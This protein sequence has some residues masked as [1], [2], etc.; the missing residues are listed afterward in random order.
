MSAGG[1]SYSGVVGD[2]KVTLPAV[3]SWGSNMN[4]LRDPPK[5]I[6][7]RKIDKVFD[8]QITELMA[9]ASVNDRYCENIEVYPRGINPSVSVSYGNYGNNGGKLLHFGSDKNKLGGWTDEAGRSQQWKACQVSNGNTMAKYPYRLDLDGD[10]RPPMYP[11]ERLEALS[12]AP[13]NVT[14]L[15]TNPFTVKFI[16]NNSCDTCEHK[17]A[18][19]TDILNTNV[20]ATNTYNFG[21]EQILKTRVPMLDLGRVINNNQINNNITSN[22]MENR[23]L[24]QENYVPQ[25]EIRDINNIDVKTQVGTNV[26]GRGGGAN[27]FD[28]DIGRHIET[29]EH[30]NITSKYNALANLD[31][32]N[33]VDQQMI[34]VNNI[35]P[36]NMMSNQSQ[37]RHIQNSHEYMNKMMKNIDN[38][39]MYTNVNHYTRDA[40]H[41][42]IELESKMPLSMAHTNTSGQYNKTETHN[43]NIELAQRVHNTTAYSNPTN[44]REDYLHNRV[45]D[46]ELKPTLS[47]N[48]S[49]EPKASLPH[50]M[51]TNRPYILDSKRSRLNKES[52]NGFAAHY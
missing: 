51:N 23:G 46:A 9:E 37:N 39:E 20:Q 18:I 45:T 29:R 33:M 32:N 49:F 35:E 26:G 50:E 41:T 6:F 12:R 11:R 7:T 30:S 36:T 15:Y 2:R 22:M 8:T 42:Q 21:E 1:I 5:Q 47:I 13:R 40:E 34:H 28:K 17:R 3:E 52:Y 14:N 24:T 4:I 48:N 19:I 27:S 31:L 38:K 44:M 16:D 10:F 25:K 43:P